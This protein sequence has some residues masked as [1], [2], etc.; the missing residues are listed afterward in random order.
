MKK[1]VAPKKAVAKAG[2]SLPPWLAKVKGKTKGGAA[3]KLTAGDSYDMKNKK[4]TV[5]KK[6]GK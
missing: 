1:K 4:K 6:K 2:K 5:A 3:D